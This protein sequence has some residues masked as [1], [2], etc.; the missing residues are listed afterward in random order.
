MLILTVGKS[1][2]FSDVKFEKRYRLGDSKN[3]C[4]ELVVLQSV[5]L[6]KPF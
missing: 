2:E 3:V 1:R 6:L 5:I 4:W